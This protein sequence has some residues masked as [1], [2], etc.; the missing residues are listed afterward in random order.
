MKKRI[1]SLDVENDIGVLAKISGLFS[2][3]CYNMDSLSV[4]TTEDETVSRITICLTGDDL[5]FEQIKKQLN[6]C[7]EVIKVTDLTDRRAVSRELMFIKVK[8][9]SAEIKAHLD[10]FSAMMIESGDQE[11][12]IQQTAEK[13]END[14]LIEIITSHFEKVE[15]V[16]GG[17]IAV[18]FPI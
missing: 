3:K 11:F 5:V 2:G 17:E 10:L 9:D 4:G 13:E 16:R 12:L 7:V 14:R 8:G 18:A 1:L 15:I 6:R